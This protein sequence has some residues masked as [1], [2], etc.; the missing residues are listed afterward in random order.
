MSGGHAFRRFESEWLSGNGKEA[1]S[2]SRIRWTGRD[3][4]IP[5]ARCLLRGPEVLLLDEGATIVFEV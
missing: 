1:T 4:L 2:F 3:R 5:L